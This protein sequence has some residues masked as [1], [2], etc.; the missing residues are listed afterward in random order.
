MD[1][2]SIAKE[3][4]T[5][6]AEVIKRDLTTGDLKD[7]TSVVSWWVE[8]EGHYDISDTLIPAM[9]NFYNSIK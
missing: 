1:I 8:E 3:I 9:F 5:F 4:V 7:F 2:E 6:R